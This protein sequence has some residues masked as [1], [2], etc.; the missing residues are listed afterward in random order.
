MDKKIAI[1]TVNYNG[2]KD[3]LEF[4]ES[5]HLLSTDNCQLTTIVVDN[6]STDGLVNTLVKDYPDVVVLQNGE[7]KGFA[8]GFNRGIEFASVWG[9]DYLFLINN[10]C[11]IKDSDLLDQLLKT[12][13]S[14]SKIGVVSP[15]IL[16]APGFEFKKDKYTKDDL[17]KVIWYGGGYFD[18]DNI[19][20]VHLGI[21]EVDTYKY[22][23]TKE[24]DFISGACMFIKREVFEKIGLFNEDYFLYFEDVEFQKRVQEVGFKEYY[25]GKVAIFHKVSKSAGIGSDLTDY[26]HTRNRLIFGMK[27]GSF[28][29]KFA[30][31]RET[32]KLFIL[33]RRAQRLGILD[34]YL[35]ERKGV[36]LNHLFEPEPQ[37]RRLEGGLAWHHR[38]EYP[39]KLS[40]GIVNYNTADLTKKLL[41]SIFK[42]ESGFNEKIMEI[43]VLDNGSKDNCKELIKQY[44][45]KIEFIQ[46]QENEGFS[47]GYN[48]TIKSAKGEY[49][50]M[51]NSDIEV[52][53]N[54]LSELVKAEDE[55]KGEAV[56]GGKL[57]FPDGS[58]QDSV[59]HLPTLLGAFKE[60]FLARRGSYFMYQPKANKPVKVEGLVM[61]CFLIP[62]RILNKVG[63][64]DEG[65]FIFFE[66]IEYCRR[67]KN[68]NVP[69]YFIPKA[70]FIHHHGGATKRLGQE[71]AYKL[72]Q[73]SARRY[74]EPLYFTLLSW[75]LRLG[76]KLGR[77]KTPISRW[78]QN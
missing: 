78:L 66:D 74:H 25:N 37:S 72:L 31:L 35:G 70:K 59:Y 53:P 57:V 7:N 12:M 21:D 63:L 60:Y 75:V 55:F 2:K 17:G 32:F 16:F 51:L 56:L 28:R 14:D 76:Q 61:A 33:G 19:R 18:W 6:G 44:L 46:N 3:T 40:I 1:I 13:E 54:A 38:V 62:R 52:L 15:K 23:G 29:T 65:T 24:V 27:Y 26:F 36:N 9:A 45:P 47:K 41:E 4:L 39:L 11:L 20:G 30:L 49:Y 69:V 50:L 58:S 71:K 64:L 67:L 43:I 5:L 8:G 48:K 22:S 42:E 77:I 68:Y 73:K 10:D 34:F